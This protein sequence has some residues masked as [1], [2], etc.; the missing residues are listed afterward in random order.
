[1]NILT[2]NIAKNCSYI[3]VGVLISIIYALF[4]ANSSFT[5]THTEFIT[6]ETAFIVRNNEGKP[7]FIFDADKSEMLI[8][9]ENG[10]ALT[11]IKDGELHILDE[12]G[13]TLTSIKQ[14]NIE[15][16]DILAIDIEALTK[17]TT[18]T[19][20][21]EGFLEA[22]G[23]LKAN[24][25]RITRGLRANT[26]RVDRGLTANRAVVTGSLLAK[27][28]DI[29]NGKNIN[30]ANGM[31]VDLTSITMD[32]FKADFVILEVRK[33]SVLEPVTIQC[34]CDTLID[35]CTCRISSG[36]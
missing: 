15:A 6:P 33:L 30:T 2:K 24:T 20:I 12:D 3:M 28:A 13:N 1:M 10:N 23:H 31:I 11:R 25:A 14:G 36:D 35:G 26:A 4:T 8:L 19:A 29:E 22:K 21:V 9:D 5:T 16:V 18:N 27:K 17:V 7:I 34:D 32:A